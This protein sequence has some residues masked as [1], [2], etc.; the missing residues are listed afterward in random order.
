MAD[1]N[2]PDAFGE[3]PFVDITKLDVSSFPLDHEDHGHFTVTVEYRGRGLWAVVR[4]G[5]C[6]N[7]GDGW[8]HEVRPSE[9]EDAWIAAH[10][11]PMQDAIRRARNVA[12]TL[13]VNGWTVDD[14]LLNRE[15]PTGGRRGR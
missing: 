7:T 13:T 11:F 8:D 12:P 4:H 6:L 2:M 15:E 10:R 3:R 14:R 9:R 5:T 1:R